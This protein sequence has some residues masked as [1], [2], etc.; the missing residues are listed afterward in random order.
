MGG[1]REG[2]RGEEKADQQ[3]SSD[4]VRKRK[5]GRERKRRDSRLNFTNT[6]T[7]TRQ[8]GREGGRGLDQHHQRT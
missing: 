4:V 7:D 1:G 6:N 5:G 3:L 2:G 8:G